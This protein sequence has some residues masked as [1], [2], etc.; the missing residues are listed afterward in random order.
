MTVLAIVALM[1][2][3]LWW[4]FRDSNPTG[5]DD[6]T[7]SSSDAEEKSYPIKINIKPDTKDDDTKSSSSAEGRLFEGDVKPQTVE[8][9]TRHPSKTSL[10]SKKERESLIGKHIEWSGFV[11]N[12][13]TDPTI[14]CIIPYK[15]KGDTSTYHATC[16]VDMTIDERKRFDFESLSRNQI[17]R[18]SGKIGSERMLYSGSH[19]FRIKLKNPKVENVYDSIIKRTV[20]PSA[21]EA[22]RA[23]YRLHKVDDQ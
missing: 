7:Q 10:Q 5:K 21:G 8:Y 3:A 15:R 20:E 2:V 16:E 4:F 17:I 19:T 12:V 6:D 14:V 1:L 9:R 11:G 18:F 22:W 13:T 23:L